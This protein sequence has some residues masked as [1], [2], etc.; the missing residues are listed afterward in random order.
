[1]QVI[2]NNAEKF[3]KEMNCKEIAIQLLALGLIP[4]SVEHDIRL[5]KSKEDA[6]ARLLIYLKQDA[7][8]ERVTKVF[9]IACEKKCFPKMDTFA[10]FMI[11]ELQLQ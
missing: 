1:M 9:R 7:D 10:S 4:E 8:E 11:K 2:Q 3:L 5:S 6:N